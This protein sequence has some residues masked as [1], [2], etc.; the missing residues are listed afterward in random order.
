MGGREFAINEFTGTMNLPGPGA[1]QAA[2][3]HFEA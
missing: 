2:K 1:E 3:I